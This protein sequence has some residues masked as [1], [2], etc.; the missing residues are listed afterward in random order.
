[1][2]LFCALLAAVILAAGSPS[3]LRA[4]YFGRN[5]VPYERF[6]FDV[7]R[8]PHWDVHY[9]REE[10][11]AARDAARMLERW[12]ARY[13]A[14]FNHQLS[15]RKPVVLYADQPDFQQT[16]VIADQLDEGTGGVTESML[17]RMVLPLTGSYAESD[18]VLG[19]ETVHEFQYDIANARRGAGSAS[20]DRLPLWVIEGMAE[21]LSMGGDDP[22]TAMW[23][24][25]AVLRKDLPTI[26][27]LANDGR[28]FPYRYGEA[29]WAY[30]GG[31]WGDETIPRIYSAALKSGFDEAIRRTLGM[32]VDSLS[33]RWR[34]A[35]RGHYT[36]LLEGRT[37]P[38]QTGNPI[39]LGGGDGGDYN[40]S[41]AVSPD[42]KWIAYFS[43]KGLRGVEL[44][45]AD[46]VT[47]QKVA[48]LA[49]PGVSTR[50]DALSFLYSAGS[51]SPDGRQLAFVT[52]SNGDN[53]IDIV[54]VAS[55]RVERRIRPRETGAISTLA[56][57]PDGRRLA[58]SGMQGGVSDLY[59]LELT[60]SDVRRLTNDRYA[61][62]QPA[63]SPDGTSLAFVSDREMVMEDGISA[64][65]DFQ[66][67]RYAPLR[68]ATIDV[69]T[70][71]VR[72]LN[73]FPH[74]KHLNPA[75]APD[76]RSIYFVSDRGG[77]SDIY[78]L[79][80]DTGDILQVT[81][82]ATGVSGI[83]ASSPAIS[84]ARESGTLAFSVFERGGFHIAT[85]TADRA[86]GVVLSGPRAGLES[87]TADQLPADSSAREHTVEAYLL[88]P[89]RGLPADSSIESRPYHAGF[90]LASLGQPSLGVGV[91]GA[92]GTQIVG[93]ASAYFSDV[94]GENELGIA[95]QASGT[96][97]DLGGQLL[98][99]N[100]AHRWKW[101]ASVERLPY[102]FGYTAVS[103]TAVQSGGRSYGA[104]AVDNVLA[105]LAVSGASLLTQFA[106]SA[107]R[108][109]ELSTGY[110]NYAY[111][112]E[113]YRQVY[114]GNSL[115]SNDRISLAAPSSLGMY[116]VSL[117]YVGD[118]AAFGFTSPISGTRY[119][120]AITP[121]IGGLAY[122]ELLVDY[123][124]Y[125]FRKPVTLAV[126]GVHYGRYGRDGDSNQLGTL[127]LGDGSLV[128]GY[129]YD[130]FNAAECGSGTGS[131]ASSTCPQ[132][133]R[134]LGSRLAV[135]NVELR[136][137]VLGARGL[138]LL[139][140]GFPPVEIA[141]FVDAG[142]AWTGTSAPVWSLATNSSDR[143]PVASAGITSRVALFGFAVLEVYYAHPFQRPGRGGVFGFTLQ[144]G[145]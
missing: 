109:F 57:S 67:L 25:D 106:T 18:H 68:L 41:P 46:A 40:V 84:V 70:G 94:L 95:A 66:R 145:W 4:Q 131:L 3:S 14:L 43:T 49:S 143:T 115:V 105:H 45:L 15:A 17:D 33:R 88:D 76:G 113:S 90:R 19:H 2:K 120:V 101:G 59:L 31:T 118:D 141:P 5:K 77:F 20:L 52:Y 74:A 99:I 35:V 38:R 24:R 34:A 78:R 117:A 69:A 21:Y 108:R 97:K 65:S 125:L 103:D 27:Q 37:A 7:L 124:K 10:E 136:I 129:A 48:T 58:F 92:F 56:W 82:A 23:L 130:S 111:S 47:G 54:D 36:P 126:R 16:N 32:S 83:A 50:F 62:L 133:D 75:Y 63:W 110:T 87:T 86:R 6:R 72:V 11:V 42:G 61:D 135:A 12:S 128:R 85:L 8:T 142:V 91:G 96:M 139:Q 53:E 73:G 116:D 123:R 102:V 119:R 71:T 1:M 114:V 30:I 13:A 80:L 132:F 127:F 107:T 9:Y 79:L 29:V 140:S 26:A 60:T 44:V 98:Y 81:R 64:G 104:T 89:D 28:Y 55:R 51:W 22:H 100:S 39:V 134:L 137:P 121:T 122:N 112:L 93:G 138:G 144:P